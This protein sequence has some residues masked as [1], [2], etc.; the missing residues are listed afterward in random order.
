MG[1]VLVIGYGNPGR[2]DD[3]LGP[4]LAAALE[5]LGLEGVTVDSDYQL[6]VEDAALVARH[7]AVVFADAHVSCTAPFEVR[8]LHPGATD[9]FSTHHVSPEAVLAL[10]R[11]LFGGEPRAFAL[12]IRGYEFDG[13]GEVLSEAAQANLER[14]LEFLVPR[15]HNPVTLEEEG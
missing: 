12:G 14:A 9:S 3:G 11:E 4:A 10:A 5:E 2:Q 1:G 7:D 8:R 6:T 13:F 15:L